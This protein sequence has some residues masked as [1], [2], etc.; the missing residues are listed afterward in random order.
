[1]QMGE[2][3]SLYN[4]L[5][6][7]LGLGAML[8]LPAVVPDPYIWGILVMANLYAFLAAGFDILLGYAGLPVIGYG[9]FV[10]VGAYLAALLNL[11]FGLPPWLT[12]PLAGLGGAVFGLLLGLSCLRLKGLYLALA[13]FAAAAICEKVVIVFYD[14]TNGHEGLSG[15]DPISSHPLLDYY[16]SLLVMAAGTA[17]LL[18]VVRS[19]VGLVLN[20]IKDNQEAAEAVGIDTTRYKLLAFVLASFLGGVGGGFLGHYTMHV[21]PNM[22]GLHIAL[23]IIM[24]A[25]VGGLGTITGSIGASYLLIILNEALREVGEA[26]LLIYT[27][28]TVVIMLAL[29]KGV[30]PPL[31]NLLHRVLRRLTPRRRR[32]WKGGLGDA[33]DT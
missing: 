23:T 19:K 9:L 21:G 15:L 11:S 2:A 18:M 3:R 14:L 32:G 10:G 30:M 33:S 4:H 17:A 6:G 22:F 12:V 13:S 8:L 1:M 28:I 20:S 24:I 7:L 27:V 26:R 29:P 5:P 16:L 25:I 31:L